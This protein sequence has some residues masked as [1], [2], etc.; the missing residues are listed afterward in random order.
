MAAQI[1]RQWAAVDW[2]T[3]C[4]TG[5]WSPTCANEDP[6]ELKERL[7]SSE[8]PEN[9]YDCTRFASWVLWRVGFPMD[10]STG[11][12]WAEHSPEQT[13]KLESSAWSNAD[14]FYLWWTNPARGSLKAQVVAEARFATLMPGDLI[15]YGDKTDSAN[16]EFPV[17]ED[18]HLD[19][20]HVVIVT[21]S[22]LVTPSNKY[23]YSEDYIGA[24]LPKVAARGAR[25]CNPS[26]NPSGGEDDWY[27]NPDRIGQTYGSTKIGLHM[28]FEGL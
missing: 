4:T 28:P 7:E 24:L 15:V 18:D 5:F 10:W 14:A 20:N 9:C 8:P 12:W 21:S 1:A 22:E 11:G 13:G 25:T 3:W 2:P 17:Y 27:F 16:P 23:P 26:D 19:L 6:S